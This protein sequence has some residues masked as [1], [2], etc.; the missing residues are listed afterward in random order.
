MGELISDISWR[1]EFEEKG[2]DEKEKDDEEKD[3]EEEDEEEEEVEEEEEEEEEETRAAL[4]TKKIRERSSMG[5]RG[6]A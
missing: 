2:E 6:A 4:P 5:K 3:D 1:K